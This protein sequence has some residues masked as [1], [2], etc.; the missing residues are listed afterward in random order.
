MIKN[1]ENAQADWIDMI[2]KSWTWAKLTEK[3]RKQFK[4]LLEHP[5]SAVVIKGN[6]EQRW[7][8]CEALYHTYLEGLDYDSLHWREDIMSEP[9]EN[10]YY[11]ISYKINGQE[12]KPL[13]VTDISQAR[14]LSQ[15]IKL[16]QINSDVKLTK[17]K[18]I[19]SEIK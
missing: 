8:A 2:S 3:E 13:T 16:D 14:K 18:I 6:Y 5:C 7:E 17:I 11:E 4:G 12:A 9:I 10:V 1:K 19:S 15:V